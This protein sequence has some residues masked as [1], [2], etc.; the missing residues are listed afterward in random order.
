MQ[1]EG[2]PEELELLHEQIRQ[3]CQLYPGLQLARFHISADYD[4]SDVLSTLNQLSES[5][6]IKLNRPLKASLSKTMARS[7]ANSLSRHL[8]ACR[9]H[10][11]PS[12]VGAMFEEAEKLCSRP[13]LSS[14][15]QCIVARSLVQTLVIMTAS[16]ESSNV[17][18]LQ[19]VGLESESHEATGYHQPS[20]EQSPENIC[21]PNPA[22]VEMRKARQTRGRAKSEL[23]R[24]IQEAESGFS[25]AP[26]IAEMDLLL[27]P[28]DQSKAASQEA[29]LDRV[30]R[31]LLYRTKGHV[32]LCLYNWKCH[33]MFTRSCADFSDFELCCASIIL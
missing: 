20:P 24:M 13:C 25:A 27:S 14:E 19:A 18:S 23:S 7:V 31:E 4:C 32:A 3:L 11:H 21:R 10:R 2:G 30:Y 5:Y 12:L 16:L 17:A 28:E 6:R 22:A 9:P 8:V 29:C 15:L 26:G 33:F 1:T